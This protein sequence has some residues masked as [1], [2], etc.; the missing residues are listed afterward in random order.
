VTSPSA[1]IFI[2]YDSN[3]V[4]AYHVLAQSI[5]EHASMPVTFAPI[6]L[7]NLDGIFTRERNRPRTLSTSF[8]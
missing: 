3:E 4:I 6:V 5:I 8:R 7:S 1:R 2:G